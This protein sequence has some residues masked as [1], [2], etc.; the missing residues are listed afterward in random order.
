MSISASLI[1][2]YLV[3]I[4]GCFFGCIYTSRRFEEMLPLWCIAIVL[5]MFVF[6]ISG[7]LA[8]GVYFVL[9]LALAACVAGAFRLKKGGIHG[10]RSRFFSPGFTLFALLYLALIVFNYGRLLLAWDDF[11]HWGDVVKV[12]TTMDVMSTSPLSNSLFRNIPRRWLCFSTC[13]K[14]LSCSAA[15]SLR[16]GRCF[17][18]ISFS[19]CP[20][21]FLFCESSTSRS[22]IHI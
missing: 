12:M 1:I 6:G 21:R 11:S 22:F 8:A 14:S 4:S 15:G 13:C 10:F 19:F 18:H 2:L 5:C 16:S 20:L 9:V 17:S 3:L 7:F